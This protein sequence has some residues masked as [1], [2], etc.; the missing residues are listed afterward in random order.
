MIRSILRSISLALILVA[1]SVRGD[2]P[3][4]K[5]SYV[6]TWNISNTPTPSYT[7]PYIPS[8][9]ENCPDVAEQALMTSGLY[10]VA[11]KMSPDCWKDRKYEANNLEVDNRQFFNSEKE[12]CNKCFKQYSFGPV[13][14]TYESETKGQTDL[15]EKIALSIARS[16]EEKAFQAF[17][18]AG[19]K[20]EDA[21]RFATPY[22]AKFEV[23]DL[24]E[25]AK[26]IANIRLK[27]PLTKKDEE[28][29][30]KTLKESAV[31][32][33]LYN[34][35]KENGQCVDGRIFLAMKQ[36][37]DAN[38]QAEFQKINVE[39]FRPEDWS[40]KALRAQ[41]SQFMAK[42]DADKDKLKDKILKLKGKIRFL[43]RNPL[44]KTFFGSN[45]VGAE[46]TENLALK[47]KL[48]S[49]LKGLSSF[50][51]KFNA[52]T[53]NRTLRDFFAQP[54]VTKIMQKENEE[55]KK[56]P[57]FNPSLLPGFFNE[58]KNVTTREGA[59]NEFIR[60]TK[61]GSP[62]KCIRGFVDVA[63]CTKIYSGFC[64]FLEK[65]VTLPEMLR[66]KPSHHIDDLDI[67]A[68]NDTEADIKKN[69]ELQ[70]FNKRAC[71][72]YSGNGK[73]FGEQYHLLTRTKTNDQDFE[74]Q[75]AIAAEIQSSHIPRAKPEQIGRH[76][77][78][79]S[80]PF[81]GFSE[82]R[83][84]WGVEEYSQKELMKF[85]FA[86][87][88]QFSDTHTTN[89]VP[90]TPEFVNYSQDPASFSSTNQSSAFTPSS[91]SSS[92]EKKVQDMS[93]DE[94][95]KILDDWK[96]QYAQMAENRS[97][98]DS[99]EEK[100][101]KT[102]IDMLERLLSEQKK[103]T[104]DQYKLLNQAIAQGK[105]EE[106]QGPAKTAHDERNEKVARDQ[107]SE[108]STDVSRAPSSI[109][110]V[111]NNGDSFREGSGSQA[112][113]SR[114]GSS[115]SADSSDDAVA[116]ENSKLVNLRNNADGS[117]TIEAI[118]SGQVQANAI[119]LPVTDE[120]YKLLQVNPAGL[121]LSQLE[122]RIPKE[123]IA[124]LEKKGEIVLILQ[125]GTNPPFEVKV[126]KK[127]NKLVYSL[128]DP[129]GQ[130]QKPVRRVH[131]LEALGFELKAQR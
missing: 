44:L 96:S 30:L 80:D 100:A 64:K 7:S 120:M 65:N 70:E 14:M 99:F 91:E 77:D 22:R 125:N 108:R 42:D 6:P 113:V 115:K 128:K 71:R 68:Q 38:I 98:Q 69:P 52:T 27:E 97:S 101:L 47:K 9:K 2:G 126:E 45:A 67:L 18:I 41:Y 5:G 28:G 88:A 86:G 102:R 11:N 103:L 53:Y 20:T 46:G 89:D 117:I 114:K 124:L 39:S 54:A 62:T 12:F 93:Q 82:L 92:P 29:L 10:Q 35:V 72:G 16:R 66:M 1:P 25:E 56:H 85:G 15:I 36:I 129:R 104:E 19:G 24:L 40:Y 13:E 78:D 50:G 106:S 81:E 34:P 95:Q 123:Q 51:K 63:E 127:N 109:N 57:K 83:S 116:R 59:I 131:K 43:D 49:D 121:N 87:E 55:E 112:S 118:R 26:A 58:K 84:R 105:K 94:R 76:R 23:K 73:V 110:P 33:K 61:L 75:V 8:L 122:K 90:V 48:L 3:V 4:V 74:D 31:A 130:D 79:T 119:T 37:P 32:E 111:S 60:S 21:I 17:V 107:S